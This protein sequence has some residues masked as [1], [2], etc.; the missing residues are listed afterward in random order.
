VT[1]FFRIFPAEVLSFITNSIPH[2]I[3]DAV[4]GSEPFPP[5][6]LQGASRKG[7]IKLILAP[8]RICQALL[9]DPPRGPED[10]SFLR[11]F[12][13]SVPCVLFTGQSKFYRNLDGSFLGLRELQ[14]PEARGQTPFK[15][16]VRQ[17]R[18]THRVSTHFAIGSNGKHQGN[19]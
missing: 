7:L 15:L 9:A 4:L 11:S 3:K 2:K 19:F 16:L 13:S 18:L 6:R 14:T 10:A 8:S 5:S 17:R 1:G 12:F